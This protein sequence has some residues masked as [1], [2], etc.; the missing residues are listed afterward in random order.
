MKVILNDGTELNPLNISGGTQVVQ[1]AE[2]DCLF[3]SFPAS[4]GLDA[5][6]TAFSAENCQFI[7][8]AEDT[9][10]VYT[11][12][13]YVIRVALTLEPAADGEE[14]R[15]TVSMGKCSYAE[16]QLLAIRRQVE[17]TVAQMTDTQLALCG[18]YEMMV[19]DNEEVSEHG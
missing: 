13:G 3:F 5:L 2:R 6:H 16:E 8:I 7:K 15:I 12:T 19:T 14:D 11:H 9:G 18:V 4:A 17:E 1:G 10:K